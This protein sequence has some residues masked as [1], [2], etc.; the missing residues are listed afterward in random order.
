MPLETCWALNEKALCGDLGYT[1]PDLTQ[2]TVQAVALGGLQG[3][4]LKA[5]ET[6]I[7]AP[8]TGIYSSAAVVVADAMGANVIACGRNINALKML[9]ATFPRVRIVQFKGDIEEDTAQILAHGPA[10]AYIELSPPAASESSHFRSC[11]A[12]LGRN[13]RV[14]LVGGSAT[15]NLHVS[16]L[17]TISKNLTIYGS[18]M[19]ES[20]IVKMLIKMAESGVLKLGKNGGQEI[21]G[22]FPLEELDKAFDTTIAKSAAGQM[23]VLIP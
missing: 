11:F 15:K 20:G 18:A 3:I 22:E 2:L 1:I 7:V 10:D 21:V 6:I 16:Y 8:A 5:G 19:Y 23:T 9:E 4:G 14:A 17:E 12:A 13:A